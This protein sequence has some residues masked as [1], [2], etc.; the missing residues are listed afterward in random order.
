[1]IDEQGW[2]VNDGKIEAIVQ[3]PKPSTRKEVQRFLGVCNWYRR[4]IAGFSQLAT[5]LTD[6]T[7]VK[8]KFRWTPSA[9][10]AF[11]K[12]KAALVSAPVLAM[13]DYGKPFAIACD[14]SDTAIGAVL[15]QETEAEE[16]P[17]SYF[18][19]KLSASERKY[20]VTERV[21][22]AVI[23]AIENFRGYIEGVKFIVY[24]DHSALS[25]L[26]CMKNPTALMSRWLL[27]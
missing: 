6:L 2:R 27:R 15:T 14:A 20:S 7:R 4:F 25:Y 18:S 11:L 5:P 24:C 22:L 19:Q 17:I 13:P 8:T 26:K 12:L 9:E 21:C 3:F 10:E 16:H 1:M 23:R